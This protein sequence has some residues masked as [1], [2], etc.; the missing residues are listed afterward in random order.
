M[1]AS[2]NAIA[3]TAHRFSTMPRLTGFRPKLRRRAT[4]QQ[5]GHIHELLRLHPR[6]AAAAPLC[7]GGVL[8]DELLRSWPRSAVAWL[9]MRSRSL[10]T[11]NSGWP[12]GWPHGPAPLAPHSGTRTWQHSEP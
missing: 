5:V 1:S 2:T 7:P 8:D 10:P 6:A 9:T 3:P 4:A 12:A 11:I